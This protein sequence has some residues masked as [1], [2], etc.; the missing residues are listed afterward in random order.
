MPGECMP[1][2]PRLRL[3]AHA[4]CLLLLGAA[5]AAPRGQDTSAFLE[6][7]PQAGAWAKY[8][9]TTRKSG[10]P[11]SSKPLQLAVVA[12]AAAEGN[13]TYTL[14]LGPTK[15]GGYRDGFLRMVLKRRP[16][17]EEVL[18]PFL[19]ALAVAYQE[20]E[21]APF[22]L[23]PSA[24]QTL[25]GQAAEAKVDRVREEL[26]RERAEDASGRSYA[27]AKVRLVTNRSAKYFFKS[28]K[29]TED[30]V[31]WF[32]EETPFR[33]VRAEL[34]VT[35]TSGGKVRRK[36]VTVLLKDSG[37]AGA[38]TKFRSEPTREKGILGVILH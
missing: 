16:A 5:L 22:K 13:P 12:E 24:M 31:Y 7:P 15:L 17:P 3:A 1:L 30:G 11:D 18:N 35:E 32:S 10:R 21:G 23:S 36:G 4:A 8:R 2:P 6:A 26:G 19:Q 33:V 28:W 27:C 14:E 20:P 25:R 38:A 34:D 29:S 37:A 9:I